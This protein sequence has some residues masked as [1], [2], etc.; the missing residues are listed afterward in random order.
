MQSSL[1]IENPEADGPG[2]SSGSSEAELVQYELRSL[3]Q[4]IANCRQLLGPTFDYDST[5]T[6]IWIEAW[7][8]HGCTNTAL[9]PVPY[10]HIKRR[11]VDARRKQTVRHRYDEPTPEVVSN[12]NG[13]IDVELVRA[14]LGRAGLTSTEFEIVYRRKVYDQKV[15]EI[16]EHLKLSTHAVT[17]H[18]DVGMDKLK[19]ALRSLE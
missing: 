14:V 4:L 7:M 10:S 16:A 2:S 8:A 12:G 15:V 11:C 5:A 13:H 3:N 1:L 18:L 9:V 6:D 17:K 19:S